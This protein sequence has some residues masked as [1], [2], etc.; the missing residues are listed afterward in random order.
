MVV[1]NGS[2]SPGDEILRTGAI[3]TRLNLQYDQLISVIPVSDTDYQQCATPLLQT[4]RAEG[5]PL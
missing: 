1:L 4:A 3:K 5:I 2:I